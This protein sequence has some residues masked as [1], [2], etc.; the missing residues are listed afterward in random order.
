M[1]IAEREL[2]QKAR[3]V[4]ARKRSKPDDESDTNKGESQT[5]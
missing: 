4:R 3:R 2:R 5:A 1:K